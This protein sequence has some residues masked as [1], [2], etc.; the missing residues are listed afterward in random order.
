MI[1]KNQS[2]GHSRRVP[3]PL[4]LTMTAA[5]AL[6]IF[7]HPAAAAPQGGNVVSGSATIS[8][9][10]STT[11]INQS[12]NRA[13]INWQGFSV[14][15]GETVNFNQPN[16]SSVTL[17]RVIG[18]ERSV[19]DGALNANGKVFL[20]NS[21]GVL[22]G[23]G[24]SVNTAG[25][26]AST[27]NITNEDF[28]AGRHVFSGHSDGE[29]VNL[30]S[31]SVN[32]GGYVV[33]LGKTV[34][35]QGIISA[36]KGMVSLNG[37][38]KVTLNFNGNSLA[39]VTLDEGA[40]NAL[41]E[42]KRAIYA[43]GGTV[44][45]SA[46]AADELFSA[47][48]N[49]TGVIQARTI[50]DLKGN[51]Q[52]MAH[53]GATR[54]DGVLDASAP[55]LGDGGFIETSGDKVR[56]ADG[57]V[58][59]TR[60]ANGRN[61][62]WLI[63]PD[64]Y[65]VGIDG[66]MT[67]AALTKALT[68]GNVEIR[69]T[70]GK[71]GDGNINVN[72]NAGTNDYDIVKWSANTLTLTATNNIYV[73]GTMTATG[74]AGFAANYGSGT[75]ADGT[76][77]G[78][79]VAQGG[80]NSS[81]LGKLNFSGS[82]GFT[83]NGAAYTVISG[84]AG[85]VAARNAPS[86]NYV[87]G[88]DF[89]LG[90]SE[91][92]AAGIG[93]DTIGFTGDFNGLGHRI[94]GVKV[95]GTGLFD[96]I[97]TGGRVSNLGLTVTAYTPD[98]AA[99]R[100]AVGLLANVNK[101]NI[102][103][104]QVTS[105]TSTFSVTTAG[106][107]A[108]AIQDAGGLVG[109]NRGLIAQSYAVATVNGVTLRAGG[110]VGTN[111]GSIIDSQ[112]RGGGVA[113]TA[114]GIEAVGGLV[115]KNEGSIRRSVFTEAKVSLTGSAAATERAGGLV[116]WNTGTIDQS[117]VY[118][119]GS[120][121]TLTGGKL[122][123][124][125]GENAGSISNSYTALANGDWA[126]G[127][128][129]RNSGSI[130]ASYASGIMPTAVNRA[131][132]GFVADNTGG[133][134]TRA[135][136]SFTSSS[137]ISDPTDTSGAIGLTAAQGARLGSYA[138][139]DGSIWG[140]AKSGHPILR[141]L[142]VF[143]SNSGAPSYGAATADVTTLGLSVFG[144]QGGA[145]NA[146]YPDSTGIVTS[147][148][149]TVNTAATGYVDAGTW[150]AAAILGGSPYT[151]L[152]GVISVKP[153]ALT[154]DVAG[155]VYDGTTAATV[156]GLTGLV[157][158]QNLA[159]LGSSATFADKN[160]G[161]DKSATVNWVVLG[162]TGTA[163]ASNYTVTAG[164]SSV[165]DITQKTIAASATGGSR[166]YD[167]T[168]DAGGIV[169]GTV[170]GVAAG[171]S[172]SL[173][174]G[175]ARFADKN[176]GSGKAVTLTDLVLSGV[177][178]A[179]YRLQSTS[180]ATT[181]TITPRALDLYAVKVAE[182]SPTVS[183]ADLL[184][185]TGITGDQLGL[186]GSVR[187]AA[188]TAGYQQIT[189]FSGLSVA[190]AN[191]TLAG[192]TGGVMVGGNTRVLDSSAGMSGIDSIT[193]IGATTSIKQSAARAIINW[194]NFSVLR[195]ETVVFEQPNASAV[196]LNRVSG[197]PTVID[198][199]LN[200]NG[201]VFIIN[202]HGV[203]FGAGSSVNVAALVASALNITDANFNAGNYLFKSVPGG[204]SITSRGV[205]RIQDGGFAVLAGG[206]GVSQ[207]G[208]LT[209]E[210][211]K[212]VAASTDQLSLT[213]A[214]GDNSLTGYGI[215]SVK[216]AT[217]LGGTMG[218]GTSGLLEAA[219]ETISVASGFGLTAG[220][221][222]W[223]QRAIAVGSGPL[224]SAFLGAN[225]AQ[226]DVT[227]NALSGSVDIREKVEWS[228]DRK[229][230]LSAAKDINVDKSITAT[231]ANAGLVMA[232]GGDYN[233]LTPASY[234]GTTLDA[235]GN[236][237]A[238]QPSAGTEYAAVTL[239]G[240]N[241]S[242]K[243]KGNT[244]TLIRSMADLAALPS[245][246]TGYYALAQDLAA[247]GTY[248]ASPLNILDGTLAGLGHKVTGLTIEQAY[249]AVDYNKAYFGLISSTTANSLIRDI[250]VTD[251]GIRITATLGNSSKYMGGLV[252]FSLGDIRN[253]YSTGN[254]YANANV[255]SAIAGGLVGKA[256]P[257]AAKTI[258]NSFST[259]NVDV[260]GSAGGLV[261]RAEYVDIT[262]SH[263]TGRVQGTGSSGGL[264]GYY[265]AGSIRSS[266]ATGMVS[267]WV[268]PI[269]G[270]VNP[271][272]SYAFNLGGLVGYWGGSL[273][274][275]AYTQPQYL[276]DSFATGLVAGGT[277]LGGLVGSV[278]VAGP[279]RLNNSYAAGNVTSY[280]NGNWTT[281]SGIGGLIGNI[282]GTATLPISITKAHAS[283][284]VTFT[285]SFGTSAGG[286][287]GV[288]S[289]PNGN[290][291]ATID[292]VY[293]SGNVTGASNGTGAAGLVG[294]T[295][296]N[297]VIS[298][299]NA[300]GNVTGNVNTGGLVSANNG[301]ITNSHAW[302]N[303]TGTGVQVGGVAGSNLGVI[304]QSASHGNVT[305]IGATI[306]TGGVAGINTGLIKS[307]D[308]YG[309]IVGGG[310]PTRTGGVVGTNVGKVEGSY[311]NRSL[312]PGLGVSG[313]YTP[314]NRYPGQTDRLSQ[315]LSTEQLKDI[316]HYRDGSIDRV[317]EQRQNLETARDQVSA[318]AAATQKS[319]AVPSQT[320]AGA[321]GATPPSV[322]G[323]ISFDTGSYS[324]DIKGIEVDGTHYSLDGRTPAGG[325]ST[326]EDEQQGK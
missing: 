118:A 158:G 311:F 17:N 208:S 71:G 326:T 231:G 199:V 50:D 64:G 272:I 19:I 274:S 276:Y 319:L 41:V 164:T 252:G 132:S 48:V 325:K 30:G 270:V 101:G 68:T 33:L 146:N 147:I 104:S 46:K 1:S 171:D 89:S 179:N 122:G 120:S 60:A 200:A 220:G 91:T 161:V 320:V 127:F 38:D 296:V 286:L 184:S 187:I 134:I 194:L 49:N 31:I 162:D 215:S 26:V 148:P 5:A 221:L 228:S 66:D 233:I 85:L 316:E 39:S 248:T 73:N 13:I 278:A 180:V 189:D 155:K 259:V 256:G 81:F 109:V 45:L 307:S 14:L 246:A 138:G 107:P 83:M 2:I 86:G 212:V 279:F 87:V 226:R 175:A 75:N 154:G 223:T 182:G 61:G 115:G 305:G 90:A 43:D 314:N 58:I 267:A 167:G 114:A 125:A 112:V 324:A 106:V 105:G 245:T 51:I 99:T 166:T 88:A 98:A 135:Y 247:T 288:V 47:Q 159:I 70:Q 65:T 261:G 204:G 297:T 312:N 116:G 240:L 174:W 308:A 290:T 76:P 242:L 277:Q 40:L 82:G 80:S 108:V 37:A 113:A 18:N 156:G 198:G 62:T 315:G 250:G 268:D 195:G 271:N 232:Y 318:I 63:D 235:A 100:T 74:T 11:N 79:Y 34:S 169:S 149:F 93:N 55:A 249:T 94:T 323:S 304:V 103:N 234:S 29:V 241:S 150:A 168:V 23:A 227:L 57:A 84:Y 264:V 142:P 294:Q 255:G 214:S 173:A 130:V 202:S 133:S 8:Q 230:T 254:I 269:T 102:V 239:S 243:I 15:A 6:L 263:A 310:D 69:S 42:N 10:G 291:K 144:L 131:R 289:T 300:Y 229:L 97:G 7:S 298:N 27:R 299:A 53:G 237:V 181:G 119:T 209:A 262:G 188:T 137:G 140:A 121:L 210:G 4:E 52:L 117:A 77:V 56:V 152:K 67:G 190:N 301:V 128:A 292:N 244:Y 197:A 313:S 236:P 157:F 178:A 35:N 295:T 193:T 196:V 224:G 32:E 129:Y 211:G 293:A 24:A 201:R 186:G 303:I 139:F 213:L 153:K 185:T 282:G 3:R 257:G 265:V 260:N 218:L 284:D 151:N 54:V 183:A 251:L 59:T 283:G 238:K 191:Y 124:F 287:I 177:D 219:G 217:N 225:L 172:V 280:Q 273:T 136:W 28:N 78:L 160:A 317:V 9:S 123:G 126:A 266:Y 111:F 165:A 275:P 321:R 322:E 72:V 192:A 222:S 285:G 216:G 176:A 21:A 306:T 143:I 253:A 205:I 96:T 20:V 206:D 170:S 163:K 309:R 22:I 258:A 95:V 12:T 203:L 207:T 110:L 44:I 16:A 302:G 25:F 281:V 36:T 92:L 145:G 141:N